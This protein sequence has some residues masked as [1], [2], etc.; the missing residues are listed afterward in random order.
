[1]RVCVCVC[2][3]VS[4]VCVCVNVCVRKK[5]R[6]RERERVRVCVCRDGVCTLAHSAANRALT[7]SKSSKHPATGRLSYTTY[8][9]AASV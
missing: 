3:F 8:D 2:V 5:E 1:M 7:W 4:G 9:W 6:E